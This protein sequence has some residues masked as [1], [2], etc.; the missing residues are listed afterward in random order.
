MSPRDGLRRV[1]DALDSH[2]VEV[3]DVNGTHRAR[4]PIHEGGSNDSLSVQHLG[5]RSGDRGGRA[6][7]RCFGGCDELQVL[8]LIGLTL[9]DLYDEPIPA[10]ARSAVREFPTC[11]AP[12]VWSG[13]CSAISP[14]RSGR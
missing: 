9:A 8:D 4:C 13:W 11:P 6:R 14:R 1:V 10:D 7:L 5:P 12:A 2:G 3:R